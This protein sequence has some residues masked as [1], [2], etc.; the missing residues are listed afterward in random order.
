MRLWSLHPKYLDSKGLVA[1][2][3]ESLLAKKV[4]ENKTK[5][6]K[7]H[8]QLIRFKNTKNPKFLINKYLETIY[9]ES[10]RRAYNFDKTKIGYKNIKTNEKIK[11]S[12]KQLIYEMKHLKKKLKIRDK[13]QLENINKIKIIEAN[14]I[15][16][17][18]NGA[19]ATWEKVKL[20]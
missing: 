18:V 7:K 4:L 1:L 10:K 2:W 3:R 9:E 8:P 20:K 17:I 15:F 11:V 5:G 12:N 19:I 13:N 16:K 6:Y 14:P